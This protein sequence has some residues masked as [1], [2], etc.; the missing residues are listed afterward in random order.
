MGEPELLG[1][2]SGP[3]SQ[4][5]PP[6]VITL[7]LGARELVLSGMWSE[8]AA[9]WRFRSHGNS[10]L[11]VASSVKRA[12]VFFGCKLLGS[13]TVLLSFTPKDLA[14]AKSGPS[15]QRRGVAEGSGGIYHELF[16]LFKKPSQCCTFTQNKVAK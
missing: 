12:P 8:V 1:S 13:T 7:P 2:P 15:G 6:H 11:Q 5:P 14:C 10:P 16:S 3:S 9:C 4:L